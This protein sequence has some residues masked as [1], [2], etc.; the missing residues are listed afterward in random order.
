M[1]APACLR[2]AAL[3]AACFLA[4]V[5]SAPAFA[6]AW[7]SK[8]VTIVVP[9]PPGGGYDRLARLLGPRLAERLKH[10]VVVDN[11]PGAGG[12]LGMTAVSR[13]PQDGHTLVVAGAG[14]IAIS[15][16]L[17]ANLPY[18]V[19]RDFLPVTMLASFPLL[20]VV[21]PKIPANTVQELVAYVGSRPGGLSY[22]SSSIGSTG[23]ISSELFRTTTGLN[24]VHVPY[25][26]TGPAVGD[27]VGGHVD[28]MITDAG[29]LIPHV[30]AGKL[31]ALAVT[32]ERRV[33]A[34]PDVPTMAE[35]G[36]NYEVTGWWGLFT[37]AGA[38]PA[39]VPALHRETV[40]I[41]QGQDVRDQ[42]ETLGAEVSGMPTAQFVAKIRT[43]VAKFGRAVKASGAKLD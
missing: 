43:D 32:T 21:H 28:M 6:Q 24:L 20:L 27:L 19:Q 11:K 14:D 5:A 10:P 38:P 42:V 33:R 22:A 4:A 36:L 2:P 17:Y 16:F 8:Q 12:T 23:H 34:L 31:R 13:A 35:S 15:P 41:L 9:Y 1:S 39:V 18:D 30:K 3:A 29:A 26:G 40:A 37:N 7:P 25:K